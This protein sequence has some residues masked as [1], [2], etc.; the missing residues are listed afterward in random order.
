M[1]KMHAQLAQM[2]ARPGYAACDGN[3]LCFQ[4]RQLDTELR[5]DY[6]RY[7]SYVAE[8]KKE[9]SS[10]DSVEIFTDNV[11][12]IQNARTQISRGVN[13]KTPHTEASLQKLQDAVNTL[14]T[15]NQVIKPETADKLK[16]LGIVMPQ[17]A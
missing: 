4:L 5:N 7:D 14:H 1:R 8:D 11:K 6:E 12:T 15:L 9:K 10:A 13:R 2:I 17:H 3:E 16:A